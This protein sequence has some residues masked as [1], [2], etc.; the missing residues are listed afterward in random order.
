V[1]QGDGHRVKLSPLHTNSPLLA[2]TMS[3]YPRSHLSVNQLGKLKCYTSYLKAASALRKRFGIK[4]YGLG[5]TASKI[6]FEFLFWFRKVPFRFIP[7][8]ARSYCLLPAGIPNEPETHQFFERVLTGRTS[9]V[10]IDV[11]AS[12]GEFAIPMAH[13]SRISKVLAYEP[14]PKSN[15]ALLESAKFTP[16]GKI[17]ITKK[18]AADSCGFANFDFSSVS[19][20]EAGL[21]TSGSFVGGEQIE[22]CTLDSSLKYE[23]GQSFIL[24]IDIEGGEFNALRGGANFIQTAHPLI[25]FEYNAT[26][27]KHFD[28]S[29]AIKLLGPSYTIFRVRSEDG[30]LDNNL[31]DTWNV[32]AIPNAGPWEKLSE[33]KDL[34]LS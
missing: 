27:R 31:S 7:S 22:I 11:G 8:A 17:Q 23:A 6:D 20:T 13:D 18:G 25:V 14:H 16:P 32:V 33:L 12:I 2:D 24:L 21:R 1:F 19:P 30:R 29:E 26:T 34:F 10:F 4:A 5:W 9:V 3:E 28:L 15:T